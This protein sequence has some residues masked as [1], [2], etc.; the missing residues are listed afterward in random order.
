MGKLQHCDRG[1]ICARGRRSSPRWQGR[2]PMS[3]RLER[4]LVRNT[5][6]RRDAWAQATASKTGRSFAVAV[7]QAICS[8]ARAIFFV[9]FCK[10]SKT[11]TASESSPRHKRVYSH[12]SARSSRA[13]RRRAF[14]KRRGAAERLSRP[15][16]PRIGAPGHVEARKPVSRAVDCA[17]SLTITPCNDSGLRFVYRFK[18]FQSR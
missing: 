8:D 11:L 18:L 13:I 12:G 9:P 16:N 2:P 5:E 1:K 6:E 4:E 7:P 10:S 17:R 15:P 14:L 3:G